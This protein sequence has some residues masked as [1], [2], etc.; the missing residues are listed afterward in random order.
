MGAITIYTNDS[1]FIIARDT[2]FNG[3]LSL[4]IF[5]G[6]RKNKLILKNLF[7]NTFG[8]S[9]KG[10]RIISINW[11]TWLAILA[12]SNQFVGS[13]YP[14]SYWITFKTFS[15]G[16]SILFCIYQFFIAHKEKLNN[17]NI[18]GLRKNALI[19]N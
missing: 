7:E 6:L 9:D 12:L 19:K 3:C 15:F 8:I 10:W 11:A 17:S 16:F 1:S 13:F 14:L 18:L 5:Q 4:I 2:I